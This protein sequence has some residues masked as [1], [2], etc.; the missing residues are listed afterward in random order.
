VKGDPSGYWR[1]NRILITVLL[2]IWALVSFV[3]SILLANPLYTIR[4]GQIPMSFW[5]AHQGSM[6]VFVILIFVYAFAMDRIDRRYDVHE[7]NE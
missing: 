6:V 2:L 4:V 5:W 7:E 1:A 3:F